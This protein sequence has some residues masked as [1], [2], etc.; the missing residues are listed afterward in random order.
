MLALPDGVAATL[1]S[2]DAVYQAMSEQQVEA[3]VLAHGGRGWIRLSAAA[4]N[5]PADY[6]RLAEVLPGVLAP[7]CTKPLS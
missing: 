4:Y 5:E 6:E 2:A 1:E 3:Q 7:L